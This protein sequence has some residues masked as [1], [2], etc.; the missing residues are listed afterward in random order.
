MD[1]HF[2]EE[3]LSDVASPTAAV[4]HLL[5][6][7]NDVLDYVLSRRPSEKFQSYS[8]IADRLA[9]YFYKQVVIEHYS[10]HV[11]STLMHGA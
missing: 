11:K 3:K 9:E 5:V 10:I 6:P 8:Q 2:D 7:S 1:P 4:R